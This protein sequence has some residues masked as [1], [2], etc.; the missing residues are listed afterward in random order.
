VPAKLG[1][2]NIK[3][4]AFQEKLGLREQKP[5]AIAAD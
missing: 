4:I 3:Q 2:L 1:F 5:A